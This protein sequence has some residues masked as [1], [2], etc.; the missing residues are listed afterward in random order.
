[1]QWVYLQLIQLNGKASF[2]NS[3]L[4][5]NKKY[6]IYLYVQVNVVFL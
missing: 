6:H 1:M 2:T 4:F 3:N 5:K